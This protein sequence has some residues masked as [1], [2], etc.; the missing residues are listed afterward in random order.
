MLGVIRIRGD[1]GA[2]VGADE[3]ACA[4]ELDGTGVCS[5]TDDAP[6]WLGISGVDALSDSASTDRETGCD[7]CS[8]ANLLFLIYRL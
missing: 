5:G 4:L 6:S 2:D 1:A 3:G 7:C 8:F